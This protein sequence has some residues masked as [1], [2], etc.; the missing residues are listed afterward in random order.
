MSLTKCLLGKYITRVDKRNSDNKISNVMGISVRKEFRIP[1][2]KVN[3]DELSTYKIVA[4]GQFAFVQ[5]THNEK[6]FAFAYNDTDEN[7]VVS[8][9]NEVFF[10]NEEYILIDLNLID[11]R[12]LILGVLREKFSN[13]KICVMLNL[14]FQ[15][16]LRNK[17]MWISTKVWLL[18]KQH[19]N[20]A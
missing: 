20:V 14:N 5:T 9:V 6:C 8:S 13:G 19:T 18:I 2:S 17:N 12:D 16:W 10:V 1:T 4:P 15:T 3:R 11:M 7:I